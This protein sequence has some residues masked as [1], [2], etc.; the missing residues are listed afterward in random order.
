MHAHTHTHTYTHTRV[1]K[2]ARTHLQALPL[3]PAARSQVPPGPLLMESSIAR[4]CLRVHAKHEQKVESRV[5]VCVCVSVNVHE[6]AHVTCLIC[7]VLPACAYRNTSKKH[8]RMCVCACTCV[9]KNTQ[10]SARKLPELQ[11]AAST[12]T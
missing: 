11:G 9:C 5:H 1:R 7:K 12:G 2:H 3:T 6:T 4:C 10:T 8:K